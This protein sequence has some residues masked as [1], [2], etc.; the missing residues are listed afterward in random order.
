MKERGGAKRKGEFSGNVYNL[1]KR[2]KKNKQCP[3][4]VRDQNSANESIHLRL[5]IRPKSAKESIPLRLRIQPKLILRMKNPLARPRLLLR[6]RLKPF[7]RIGIGDNSKTTRIASKNSDAKEDGS[8]FD[9][10]SFLD[11]QLRIQ[12][13]DE[14]SYGS[15]ES[16]GTWTTTSEL[17][18]AEETGTCMR[19]KGFSRDDW[20]TR[21]KTLDFFVDSMGNTNFFDMGHNETESHGKRASN[22]SQEGSAK[23]NLT[24]RTK[25]LV[26]KKSKIHGKG[27][28]GCSAIKANAFVIEFLGEIVRNVIADLRESQYRKEGLKC[29]YLFQLSGQFILDGT[30]KGGLARYLNHSCDPNLKA[31]KIKRNG[32]V[33]IGLYSRRDIEKGEE[34]TINYHFEFEEGDMRVPCNCRAK[35]CK[36]FLN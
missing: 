20:R 14:K 33:H 4:P 32:K 12:L 3:S 27:L 19:T 22:C 6:L 11:N 16:Y 35:K 34:L 31:K 17:V 10:D 5:R 13:E 2:P 28:F 36:G 15:D 1:R 7:A 29:T 23:N 25:A 24:K 8:E 18:P 26:F 9:V 21:K 30:K